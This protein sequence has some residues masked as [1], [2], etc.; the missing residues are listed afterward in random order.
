MKILKSSLIAAAIASSPA[1]AD[2]VNQHMDSV[3]G[4]FEEISFEVVDSHA[5]QTQ[6]LDEV[7]KGI[8]TESNFV[9]RSS[10]HDLVDKLDKDG[11]APDINWFYK[12]TGYTDVNTGQAVDL[13]TMIKDGCL[14]IDAE[15][16]KVAVI[17]NINEK[18]DVDSSPDFFNGV[19]NA[20]KMQS[21]VDNA[22]KD[23]A[24]ASNAAFVIHDSMAP[25]TVPVAV[26]NSENLN[27]V[28]NGVTEKNGL[29]GYTKG[30]MVYNI[31]QHELFHSND[32]LISNPSI[33][34]KAFN[35]TSAE[36]YGYFMTAKEIVNDG[37]VS[38]MDNFNNVFSQYVDSLNYST[39]AY[40]GLVRD[41]ASA[42]TAISTQNKQGLNNIKDP[43]VLQFASDVY[44][45]NP[46][47]EMINRLERGVNQLKSPYLLSTVSD[48]ITEAVK[49]SPD[50]FASMD[51]SQISDASYGLGRHLSQH[52]EFAQYFDASIG[53]ANTKGFRVSFDESI[54]FDAAMDQESTQIAL[55]TPQNR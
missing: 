48:Q 7:A 22:K 37:K 44:N 1:L 52:N 53:V 49:Q 29:N 17:N 11:V 30:A 31:V 6:L 12:D 8:N 33:Q 25:D 50:S 24:L 18:I 5:D 40:E 13:G 38:E 27:T 45:S 43:S 20:E 39:D 55:A 9:N 15:G 46:T 42:Y 16:N 47:S 28:F 54:I 14:C 32:H 10:H 26:I 3:D 51:K 19:V 36:S 35:E 41:M 23:P 34:E 21:V 4:E 2:N